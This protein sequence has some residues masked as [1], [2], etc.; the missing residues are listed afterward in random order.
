MSTGVNWRRDDF[1]DS[2]EKAPSVFGNWLGQPESAGGAEVEY[3][4]LSERGVRVILE[5]EVES[6]EE[7]ELQLDRLKE[8]GGTQG[9]EFP[10]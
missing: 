8:F 5:F 4:H 2:K 9:E 6:D 1:R 10:R 3:E 7:M